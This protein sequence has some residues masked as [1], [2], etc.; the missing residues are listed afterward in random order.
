MSIPKNNL[1]ETYRVVRSVRSYCRRPVELIYLS[2][3]RDRFGFLT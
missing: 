3:F 1:A 2:D